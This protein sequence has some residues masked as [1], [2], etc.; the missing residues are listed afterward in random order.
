MISKTK[1]TSCSK[2]KA[3]VNENE[4]NNDYVSMRH[5]FG[6]NQ[7]GMK[8]SNSSS[9]LKNANIANGQSYVNGAH[10]AMKRKRTIGSSIVPPY[11]LRQPNHGNGHFNYPNSIMNES[12]GNGRASFS[13]V[14][15]LSKNSLNEG[16][17]G[18][19][20]SK[21]LTKNPNGN[22]FLLF[23]HSPDFSL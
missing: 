2:N 16:Y 23:N 10:P 4:D 13:M 14:P 15:P 20:M 21:Q 6:K 18:V 5:N 1:D 11:S 3:T 8:S 17:V 7:M 19:S 9:L 22:V 12:I